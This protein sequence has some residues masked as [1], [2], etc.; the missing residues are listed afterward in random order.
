MNFSLYLF[1]TTHDSRLSQGQ[2]PINF[3][4]VLCQMIDM[5]KPVDYNSIVQKDLIKPDK[6]VASGEGICYHATIDLHK[7]PYNSNI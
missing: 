4:D 7:Y 1:L 3:K 5:I 6:R 2:E